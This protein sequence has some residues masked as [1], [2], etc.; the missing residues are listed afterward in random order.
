MDRKEKIWAISQCFST[1]DC[2]K[3]GACCTFLYGFDIPTPRTVG[4]LRSGIQEVVIETFQKFPGPCTY[5]WPDNSCSVYDL[6]TSHPDLFM[7][8]S[9][10]KWDKKGTVTDNRWVNHTT[11]AREQLLYWFLESIAA[12]ISKPR[13]PI[14]TCVNI[15]ETL[16]NTVQSI[17]AGDFEWLTI[18][19]YEKCI[20]I[21]CERMGSELFSFYLE[22]YYDLYVKYWNDPV[23]INSIYTIL[24]YLRDSWITQMM[25]EKSNRVST[26]FSLK[27]IHI[28]F[29]LRWWVEF[30]NLLVLPRQT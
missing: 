9:S 24:Q 28:K 27:K 19:G 11:T 10:F 21:L 7:H 20:T 6:R 23:V 1:G 8:C 25:Y 26:F 14:P 13:I 29:I 22:G 30:Y 16:L 17:E 18:S 15:R 2:N 12:P 4:A 5:L 3:C